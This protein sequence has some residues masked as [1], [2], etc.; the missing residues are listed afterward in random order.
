[1]ST[2]GVSPQK[3][4][5]KSAESR[6]AQYSAFLTIVHVIVSCLLIVQ[7]VLISRGL[8]ATSYGVWSL[9]IGFVLTVNRIFD[10]QMWQAVTRFVPQFLEERDHPRAAA[11]LQFSCLI[12]GLGSIG[13]T[14]LVLAFAP[15]ASSWLFKDGER[16]GIIMLYA[17]FPITIMTQQSMRGLLRL[18]DRF[19]L[20]AVEQLSAAG[21]RTLALAAIVWVGATIE[22]V[23]I[24]QF[25]V[26]LFSSLML[27]VMGTR[28]A[29]ALSIPLWQVSAIHS[30]GG[31]VREILSFT[32]Y[33]NLIASS[34]IITVKADVLILG[35]Y[36][37]PALVGTYSLARAIVDHSLQMAEPLSSVVFPELSKLLI[38][39]ELDAAQRLQRKVTGVLTVATIPMCLIALVLAPWVIPWVFGQQFAEAVGYFQIIVWSLLWLPMLWFSGYL[40]LTGK[41]RLLTAL[42]WL[43][44]ISYAL[45]LAILIPFLQAYGAALC[46]LAR[47]LFW[48][49]IPYFIG[50]K[51]R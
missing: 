23:M 11:I 34:R 33:S 32:L 44:A 26:A 14:L 42:T 22:G 25:A 27:L 46:V 6:V 47:H 12:E 16:A 24:T 8:G 2:S 39:G 17:F 20:L 4:L 36:A 19:D 38:R 45:L 15:Y 29:W 10:S 51:A 9:V 28:A 35:I 43:E 50:F 30:L 49:L 48:G 13:A 7:A 5:T 18:S 1:M 21:I 40:M 41:A 3:A 37:P 31:R